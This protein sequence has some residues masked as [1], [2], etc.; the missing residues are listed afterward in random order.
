MKISLLF[1]SV[2]VTCCFAQQSDPS[3]EAASI[4]P[5][6]ESIPSEIRV[7]P[8]SLV[9]RNQPFGFLVQWAYDVA[10]PQ[11]EG[12]AWLRDACFDISA[13][14]GTPADEA[15]L[16]S[17]LRKLLSDRFGLKLHIEQRV[18]PVYVMTLAKGGPKFHE[19]TTEGSAVL[20]RR[21]PVILA[22]HHMRMIDLAQSIG[23]E[24]GRPVVDETGL[25]GRYEIHMDVS[26][27]LTR[28]GNEPQ[29]DIQ[30]IL[31]TGLQDLL[32]LKLDAGKRNVEV[33]VIDH[34]EKVPTEN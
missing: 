14:A 13:K 15:Q 5:N 18:L 19:S 31:F 27:Y 9:I 7:S 17:M 28:A 34:A 23:S 1:A 20:E 32:G 16:R 8:G 30:A 4:R 29:L 3:F 2:F 21:S 11:I 26:P 12:P 6:P 10:R 22:A 24:I 33:L 25:T